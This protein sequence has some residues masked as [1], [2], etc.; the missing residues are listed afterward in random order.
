[1]RHPVYVVT[2]CQNS[3]PILFWVGFRKTQKIITKQKDKEIS[4]SSSAHCSSAQIRL[5]NSLPNGYAYNS[6][7]E[8]AHKKCVQDNTRRTVITTESCQNYVKFYLSTK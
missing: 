1:M 5:H 2:C 8:I 7:S 3:I 4:F 6:T